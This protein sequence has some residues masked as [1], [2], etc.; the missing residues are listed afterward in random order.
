VIPVRLLPTAV[1]TIARTFGMRGAALRA[2]HEMRRRAG[3]FR[4]TPRY[5]DRPS[6]SA[7]LRAFAVD[8]RAIAVATDRETA[9]ARAERVVAGGYEAYRREWRPMPSD[10]VAWLTNPVT[11]HRYSSDTPWWRVPHLSATAGD[12]KDVWEPAR[13]AW[14][15]DLVR[16]YLLTG[17]DRYAAAFHRLLTVWAESS[18]PF[19]GVHWS[20]G[21]ETTIRAIALLYAEA[22][23]GGAAGSTDAAMAHLRALLVASGERIADA[24]G[25]AVSQRNNHAIS[26]AVGLMAL[27]D[28]FATMHP[29]ADRWLARGTHLLERLI[30]E[31]FGEDGWYIQHSFTYLRLA[32]DQCVIA[33][34][35]LRARGG[36]LSRAALERLRAATSLLLA[37]I[38]QETGIVPNHGA[39]D[40]AFVHPITLARYRDF[41]PIVTAA[42]ASFDAPLPA[43]VAADAEVLAWL[44]LPSPARVP[45]LPGGVRTGS[46][47]WAVARL[48]RT[49]A[50]L[51]AGRYRARPSH[52][53]PLHLDLRIGGR[54]VVIDPGSFAY[55]APPPWRNALVTARVHNGPLLDDAE[56]GVRGPRFLWY[57]WP[58]SRIVEA[59]ATEEDATIIAEVPG[60]I[61]R[62]VHLRIDAVTVE[63]AVLDPG[64]AKRMTVRWLLHPQCAESTIASTPVARP[65]IVTE[66]EPLGWFSEH[67]GERVPARA[68]IIECSAVAGARIIS[69]IGAHSAS[70]P[71]PARSDIRS[72]VAGSA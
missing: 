6:R 1:A 70:A 16:A 33:Q 9:I 61:R 49:V 29:E 63:D 19:R 23:L 37:V 4:T 28:R 55:Q 50:F 17:E 13:F 12:I 48:G 34:R 51:R 30:H 45:A 46:S 43:D 62:T 54:E 35:V 56:P 22:N 2:V 41:R 11:G 72:A 8:G 15:Y 57:A 59:N 27:G 66:N 25:Y 20:C 52:L 42:C 67:Y 7:S 14:A 10:A 31:Q 21:Q 65:V 64:T 18:P 44:G 26:E 32:L 5:V 71:L 53:D 60:R 68:Y 69:R 24:I 3:A 47:G 39:N 40:G 58:E 38:D 36:S